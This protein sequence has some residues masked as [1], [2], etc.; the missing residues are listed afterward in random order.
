[1]VL[2]TETIF[3]LACWKYFTRN[4]LKPH[5]CLCSGSDYSKPGKSGWRHQWPRH[6]KLLSVNYSHLHFELLES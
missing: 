4:F 6:C 5:H 2:L 1:M 3:V